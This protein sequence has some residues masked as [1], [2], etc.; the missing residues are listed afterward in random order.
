MAFKK[1]FCHQ[2]FF[3]GPFLFFSVTEGRLGFP[4]VQIFCLPES[5]IEEG[6]K[7]GKRETTDCL[8]SLYLSHPLHLFWLPSSSC[9]YSRLHAF[10]FTKVKNAYRTALTAKRPRRT[11]FMHKCVLSLLR[12]KYICVVNTWPPRATKYIQQKA[13]NSC[14]FLLYEFNVLNHLKEHGLVVFLIHA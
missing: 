6:V 10:F 5:K 3:R 7:R 8:L 13:V 12:F 14:N 2:S 11:N 4:P 9:S 1:H